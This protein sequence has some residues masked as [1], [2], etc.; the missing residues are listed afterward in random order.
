MRMLCLIYSGSIG[1]ARQQP[2]LKMWNGP[3]ITP[4]PMRTDIPTMAEQVLDIHHPNGAVKKLSIPHPGF[5]TVAA[6]A[7]DGIGVN[8]ECLWWK[9][10]FRTF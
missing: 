10:R 3:G 6:S 9:L 5:T 8:L 7:L 2:S 1:M 4:V